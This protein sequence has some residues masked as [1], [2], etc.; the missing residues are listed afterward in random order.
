VDALANFAATIEGGKISRRILGAQN[1][2]KA[3]QFGQEERGRVRG[4]AIEGIDKGV[5]VDINSGGATGFDPFGFRASRAKDE[6]INQR[7]RQRFQN[8]IRGI[9]G[10]TTLPT[11]TPATPI[12]T[13][14]ALGGNA[15]AEIEKRLSQSMPQISTATLE[16]QLSQLISLLGDANGTL[17]SISTK[18]P[19]VPPPPQIINQRVTPPS[20]GGLPGR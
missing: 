1:Q 17:V 6:A 11:V 20:N 5:S 15:Q 13:S 12:D 16:S 18:K 4:L 9:S 3:D 7:D 14:A 8:N 10:R 19:P 2:N